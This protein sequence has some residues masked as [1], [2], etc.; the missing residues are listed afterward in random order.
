MHTTEHDEA[1]GDCLASAASAMVR[2]MQR[3]ATIPVFGIYG[4]GRLGKRLAIALA[5][6]GKHVSFFLDAAAGTGRTVEGIPC[7]ARG[8]ATEHMKRTPIVVALHNPQADSREVAHQLRAE[9]FDDVMLLQ[10]VVDYVP[11]ISNFWLAPRAVTLGAE[12]EIRTGLSHYPDAYSRDVYLAVLR[13]RL[14]GEAAPRPEPDQYFP[15]SLPP[16]RTPMRFVDAG[17]Y[18]GDTLDWIV[19]RAFQLDWCAAFEPD[20]ANYA[21]LAAK[22]AQRAMLIPCA[23]SDTTGDVSF[24]PD[25]S[26]GRVGDGSVIVRTVPLDSVVGHE[27]VTFIKM[28]I[29]GGEPLALKGSRET[30]RR[31]QPRLAVASYH[32]PLHMARLPALLREIGYGGT[33]HLRPH[34]SNTFETV[35][36]GIEPPH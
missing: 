34:A 19:E 12:D 27:P 14:L 4:A 26:A 18:D 5:A 23:L 3:C 29:E 30:I 21:K 20:M 1:L 33:F 9:G 13:F 16:V 17:A 2:D 8:V 35:L 10:D 7:L 31:C 6:K 22:H 36:Y 15:A 25:G 32:D 24:T 28:D 11:E